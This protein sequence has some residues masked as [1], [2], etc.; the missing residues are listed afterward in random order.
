MI[1]L[2]SRVSTEEQATNGFSI[3]AQKNELENYANENSLVFKHYSD[4]G[5]SGGTLKRPALQL[6]LGDIKQGKITQVVFVKLDRWFRSVPDYYEIQKILE[7]NNVTWR[8]LQEDYETETSSGKFKV[9]IMLSVSQQFKDATSERIKSVFKYKMDNGYTVSSKCP[10]GFKTTRTDKG[11]IIEVENAEMIKEFVDK[12]D[13]YGSL[14]RAREFINNKYDINMSFHSATT[15]I[16]SPLIYGEFHE[17]QIFEPIVSKETM[18]RILNQMSGRYH[19]KAKTDYIFKSLIV[20]PECGGVLIGMQHTMKDRKHEYKYSRYR[21]SKHYRDHEC[22]YKTTI[23]ENA[24]ERHLVS[25]FEQWTKEYII[26]LENELETPKIDKKK[27]EQKMKRLNDMYLED[28][29]TKEYFDSHYIEL[30]EQL[31]YVP[32]NLENIK[33]IVEGNPM[34]MYNQLTNK[35]KNHFWRLLIKSVKKVNGEYIVDFL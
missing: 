22:G 34:Q 8:A 21:C 14:E 11:L 6:L 12:T 15:L 25:N 7:D 32:P 27:I 18:T 29:C 3:L 1:A 26:K 30:K 10:V 20:C 31:D 9:N 33:R 28:R 16:H 23:S 5:Y 13:S 24:L 19:P 17:K 35:E 4:E 2:Y